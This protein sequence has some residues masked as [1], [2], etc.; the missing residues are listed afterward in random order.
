MCRTK[1]T[2]IVETGSPAGRL[3]RLKRRPASGVRNKRCAKIFCPGP[4]DVREHAGMTAHHTKV[5]IFTEGLSGAWLQAEQRVCEYVAFSRLKQAAVP[6]DGNL[7]F[8]V[9]NII[10]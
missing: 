8:Y 9:G 2:S 5:G 10:V 3:K 7:S 4:C 1:D 6:A